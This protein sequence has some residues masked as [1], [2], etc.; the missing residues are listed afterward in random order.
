MQSTHPAHL[1]LLIFHHPNT[2]WW[3]YKSFTSCK[4]LQLT[5]PWGVHIFS[6]GPTTR[7]PST[8]ICLHIYHV[9]F[10]ARYEAKSYPDYYIIHFHQMFEFLIEVISTQNFRIMNYMTL[11]SMSISLWDCK[12]AR[13]ITAIRVLKNKRSMSS[14][15][16]FSKF[17]NKDS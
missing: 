13:A 2:I 15:L 9:H 16:W 12:S 6:S 8:N 7:T 5:V 11:V 1:I 10:Y 4:F 14:I 17:H 3:E